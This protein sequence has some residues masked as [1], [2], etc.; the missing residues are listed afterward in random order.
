MTTR[1]LI[2]CGMI[3][4]L[5]ALGACSAHAGEDRSSRTPFQDLTW[6]QTPFGPLASPVVGNFASGQH[7]TYIKFPGGMST[8]L[9][10]HTHTYTGMVIAGVSRH[11]VPGKPETETDLPPGSHWTIAANQPHVS[12]CLPGP[13]CIMAIFQTDPFD[14]KPVE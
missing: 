9:H 6:V 8:P 4:G 3:F 14:F 7:V 2:N 12:M 5:M 13:E 1:N 11:F 10:T